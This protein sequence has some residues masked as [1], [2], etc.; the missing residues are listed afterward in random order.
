MKQKTKLRKESNMKTK[1]NNCSKI[2]LFL[3]VLLFG[4]LSANAY[5]ETTPQAGQQDSWEFGLEIYL[6]GASIGGKTGTGS[7]IDVNFDALLEDLEMGF[8]GAFGAR[9][10]KWSFIADVVYLDVEDDTMVGPIKLSAVLTGWVVTPIVGYNLVET[11]KVRLDIV[12]G[13]RYLYLDTKLGLGP[14][15]VDESATIWDGIVGVRGDV[16]LNDKWYVPYYFDIGTG[17]S[18]LTWEAFAGVGYKF[19]KFDVVLAYRY[20][21]WDFDDADVITEL[22]FNGPLLGAKWVF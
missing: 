1:H 19:N 16:N 8:M 7:S 5:A 4:L 12:G 22:D 17:D 14:E 13:A 9:K 20:L 10:G 6:W 2:L 21:E 11:E 3:G 15:R 18:D